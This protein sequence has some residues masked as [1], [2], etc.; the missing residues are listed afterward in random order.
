MVDVPRADA[1]A[2]L[3][4]RVFPNPAVRRAH[5][6]FT[7]PAAGPARVE[8]LDIQGRLVRTL[9]D[10]PSL[11]AGTHTPETAARLGEPLEAGVYFYRVTTRDAAGHGRLVIAR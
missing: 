5:L 9:L 10:T 8:L 1:G 4:L 11:V 3:A 7:L 2:A 6:R